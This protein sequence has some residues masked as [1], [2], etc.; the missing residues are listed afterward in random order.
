M[1]SLSTYYLLGPIGFFTYSIARSRYLGRSD[2][3]LVPQKLS[4]DLS[5][6][7]TKI[8]K[9]TAFHDKPKHLLETHCSAHLPAPKSYFGVC[10]TTYPTPTKKDIQSDFLGKVYPAKLPVPIIQKV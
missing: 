4:I 1:H 10:F 6:P 9:R 8:A 3:N 2:L 7:M 5:S